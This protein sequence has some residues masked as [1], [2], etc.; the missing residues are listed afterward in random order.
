MA[1]PKTLE[2][3]NR[4]RKASGRVYVVLGGKPVYLGKYGTV[5]SHNK[6]HA[7]RSGRI[8][9]DGQ[10]PLPTAGGASSPTISMVLASFL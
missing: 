9:R 4:H 1:R 5:A 8:A 10:T 2:P 3:K 6:Y 7:V